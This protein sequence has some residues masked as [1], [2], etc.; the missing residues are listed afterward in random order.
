[1]HDGYICNEEINM[2]KT[3]VL[4]NISG[5]KLFIVDTFRNTKLLITKFVHCYKHCNYKENSDKLFMVI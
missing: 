5:I 4:S 2:Y 3:F 1:M